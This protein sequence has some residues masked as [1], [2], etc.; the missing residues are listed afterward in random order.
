MRKLL[1]VVASF[2]AVFALSAC[3]TDRGYTDC[4]TPDGTQACWSSED[5]RFRWEEG[6]VIE[7]GVDN[8]DM[9]AALVA[10][11]NAAYPE[12]QDKVVFRNYGSANGDSSGVQGIETGQG[13]A[14]DVALVI[15]NEVTGRVANLLPL[16]EYFGDLG[17]E[18]THEVVYETI[19]AKGDY[20]LPAFYDGMTFSWNKTMLEALNVDLTDENEDGLPEAFDTW[21]EIFAMAD[22]TTDRPQFEGKDILEW[23]P[24]SLGEPWSAYSSLTAGGWQLF[25]SGDL[26]DPGFDDPAF[27]EG[28]AFIK[29]FASHDMSVDETGTKKAAASMGWRWD[30]Y[31][32]GAYPF[33]L[34]GTWM[35]VDGKE[36]EHGYDFKFSAMPTYD[37]VQLTPLMK[38]KGFV[39]NAFTEYPSAASEVLRW[40]YT[41]DTIE[42]MINSSAYLP[43]LQTDASIYPVI[44]SENKE[45]FA[46][47]MRFNTLEPAGSLPNADTVRAM[48]VYYS[49]SIENFYR[50]VWDGT[51]TPAAAQTDIHSAAEQWVND[52]NVSE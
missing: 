2:V 27:Q 4:E 40:L 12:L 20:Y 49:I 28:L 51:M 50:E 9:G 42:V 46:Y 32:D 33:S 18:Q 19:N 24:I 5:E 39:V 25:S 21:E 1:L 14:P 8:D 7:I 17:S 16:H 43:A 15:D 41:Q 37:G 35:N 31:L 47:G 29:E 11:W 22:E 52:N 45:E 48:N 10:A 23:Y 34:V 13:E 26:T 3:N 44:D 6:A 38:T 36:A 30:A